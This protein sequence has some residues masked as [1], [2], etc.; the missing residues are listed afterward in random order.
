M[1][2][3]RIALPTELYPQG[4]YTISANRQLFN[5]CFSFI[6]IIMK[7]NSKKPEYMTSLSG[8]VLV[9]KNHGRIV[10][11]G[12]VD[13]LQSEIIEAQVLSFGLGETEICAKLGEILNFLRALMAAEVKETPL[14]PPCLFGLY[15]EEIH[16][17]SHEAVIT[18]S[19]GKPVLPDYTQGPLSAR[20][21]TLRAKSRE[22]ELF[23]VKVFRPDRINEAEQPS[24][25]RADIIL[26]LN[27]LSSAFWL[28]TCESCNRR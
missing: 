27:R 9:S 26:A 16:R 1:H 12:L 28:L 8:N 19:E 15:A 25:E 22:L 21:N 2:C 18:N 23:S 5:K 3:E 10:F 14:L 20:L 17:Q 13:T 6:I 4:A 11:R 7:E 24:H